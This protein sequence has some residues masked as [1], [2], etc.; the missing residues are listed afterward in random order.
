MKGAAK[1]MPHQ[2]PESSLDVWVVTD[3]YGDPYEDGSLRLIFLKEKDANDYVEEVIDV[4]TTKYSN[5]TIERYIGLWE[6]HLEGDCVRWFN[7]SPKMVIEAR[8]KLVL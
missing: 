7:V 8:R 5:T 1:D 2:E 6:V 3:G 4:I